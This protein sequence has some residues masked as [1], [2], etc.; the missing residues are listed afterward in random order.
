MN[1]LNITNGLRDWE[2][3]INTLKYI[4]CNSNDYYPM[5]L[6]MKQVCDK[7]KSEYRNENN[8]KANPSFAM[9]N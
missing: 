9:R 7:E 5:Y 4:I 8:L 2:F 3:Q 6:C 1:L